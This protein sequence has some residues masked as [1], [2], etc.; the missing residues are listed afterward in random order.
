MSHNRKIFKSAY[1]TKID[2]LR[3][4]LHFNGI[5]KYKIIL[6][7]EVENEKRGS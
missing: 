1:F 3:K 2:E 7:W 6:Q 4:F 5:V